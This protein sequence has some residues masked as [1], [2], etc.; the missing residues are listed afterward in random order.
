MCP[1][2]SGLPSERQPYFSILSYGESVMSEANREA[3]QWGTAGNTNYSACTCVAHI[4]KKISVFREQLLSANQNV[5]DK[6]AK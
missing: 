4:K 1:E 2:P 5:T 6:H 3:Q